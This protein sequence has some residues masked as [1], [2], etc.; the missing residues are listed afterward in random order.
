VEWAFTVPGHF[1]LANNEGK[2]LVKKA[3][4]GRLPRELLYRRKQGFNVPLK[5][6]MREELRPYIRDAFAST[7]FRARGLYRP[8][9]VETLLERHF[10]GA[11][12]CSNKIFA[13]LMLELWHQR[14]T[15]RRQRYDAVA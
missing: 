5:L 7:R 6:W 2:L 15:D 10:S 8:K 3:M 11:A 13:M 14:F 1:K 4:E 12:D 9:A